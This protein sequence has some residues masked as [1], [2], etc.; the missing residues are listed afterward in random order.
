MTDNPADW[1][2]PL[3]T[4][5]TPE[6]ATDQAMVEVFAILKES[7]PSVELALMSRLSMGARRAI[8]HAFGRVSYQ[9]TLDMRARIIR[10]YPYGE[11]PCYQCDGAS[12]QPDT[13]HCARCHNT[14]LEI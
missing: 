13:P 4:T 1:V 10:L 11:I 12:A 2:D 3:A 6:E 8:R 14:G 9:R 5:Y 7:Y